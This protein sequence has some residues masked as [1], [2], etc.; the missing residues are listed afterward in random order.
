MEGVSIDYYGTMNAEEGTKACRDELTVKGSSGSNGAVGEGGVQVRGAEG[1]TDAQDARGRTQRN[2]W[3]Q[4]VLVEQGCN[5]ALRKM[6]EQGLRG[7][8]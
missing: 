3:I 5:L 2:Q 7:Q 4:K 8:S 1:V 6:W